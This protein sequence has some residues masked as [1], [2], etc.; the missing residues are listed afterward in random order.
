MTLR[1]CVRFADVP[2]ARSVAERISLGVL[3]ATFSVSA[4][5]LEPNR[6]RSH[7]RPARESLERA[8]ELFE[9]IET[10]LW[11]DRAPDELA[12]ISGRRAAFTELTE[13][14]DRVVRLAASGLTNC[15]IASS[16]C[17][18]GR[19][20]PSS[21][22]APTDDT[23]RPVASASVSG[24][25]D[26]NGWWRFGLV[27][28]GPL[29]RPL[30]RIRVTG[31]EH[32]PAVGPGILAANHV[33]ALDGVALALVVARSRRRMTRFLTA[34]EFFRP[35]H[36]WALRLYRQ[37]PIRRNGGDE[38]ALDEAIRTVR[39]GAIAGVFPEGRVNP[40]P[41]LGLQR[42]RTGVARVALATGAPIVPIGIWGT[43]RR[44]PRSGLRWDRPWRPTIA[45]AFG[46]PVPSTDGSPESLD[47]TR[48]LT[49]QV[50]E[51][52]ASCAERARSA[53]G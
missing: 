39:G 11:A 48:R 17:A 3:E 5:E 10:P 30:F 22:S 52:I 42:G 18:R 32:V 46:P 14:E 40:S 31:V 45:L 12:R 27:V 34:V 33:S 51:A 4:L 35:P 37:I 29:A 49:E 16:G 24:R 19:S 36:G 47:D 7:Q 9:H 8:L 2:G 20:S 38:G 53:V 43:Q 25:G 21:S 1:K 26:L 15:E 23:R 13:A 28:V 6:R 50:M 44:W 41:E